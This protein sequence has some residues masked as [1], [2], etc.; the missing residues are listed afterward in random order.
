M[1][2][3]IG[4]LSLLAVPF[5]IATSVGCA[6]PPG[7]FSESNARAH[8]GMLAGTI[9]SRPVGTPANA[10]AR[11]YITE[12]LRLFGFEVRVQEADAR[13]A[14]LG[15]TARVSNIIAV[16]PGK[17]AEAMA[18][19]SHY[20]SVPEGP[21]AADNAFGVGVS[22]EAARVLAA[23]SDRNWTLMILITDGEEAGLMGAA[24]LVTDREIT[25]RLQ[26]YVNLEAIG[27][28]G[29]PTL[30]E[31]GPGNAWIVGPWARRAPHPSGGSFGLEIY[32]RLPND[33]DFSILKHQGIPG[34]N[35]AVVED[36]YAY[37]TARDTPERLSPATVRTAGEQVVAIMTALDGVD[38]TQRSA[39]TPTFFDIARRTAFFYSPIAN[40]ISAAAALLFGVVAWVRVTA[41]VIRLE[42]VLRWVLTTVWT[43][44]GSAAVIASMVGATWALRA[45]REVYHPWY[46]RPGRLFLL[47]IAVGLTV[48]WSS[49]RLGQWLPARAHGVRHPLVVWSIALPGWVALGAVTI[50]LVPGAAYLWLLPLLSAG[51]L[52]SIVPLRTTLAVR[53]VSAVVLLVSAALWLNPAKSM[54]FFM[55]PM[56][57]RLPVVTPSFVFAAVMAVAGLMLVPPLA[58]TVAKSRPFVR[59]SLETALCLI[60]VAAT[61]G[62][63]YV[64]PGYTDEQPLRR[65]ARAIQEGDG[66]ALWDVGSIEPGLDLGEG[67]PTG[68]MPSNTAPKAAVPLQRLPQP[69]VF[70]SSGPT[71]GPAPITIATATVEP[72]AAGA[73]LAVT[74]LPASPGLS[75]AFVL[76]PGLEP[77]RSN[78]PGVTRRDHWTATYRAPTPE[79]LVFRASFGRVD[80]NRLREL[81]VVATAEGSAD[82]AIWEVPPW[83]PS[84]RT[85]WTVDACWIVAPFALPI[86]PVPPLR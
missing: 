24:A 12:Q 14:S 66:P 6:R 49:A 71:L 18:I 21:G 53:A 86:A 42:G 81:R 26:A 85:A 70:R 73:E 44:A 4:R 62:F 57:G 65:S 11:T 74:V 68:W 7:L 28:S 54:L 64:A 36:S 63:A 51:L 75:I 32:R 41:V 31:T 45:A 23:R 37:H 77:A 8:I 40:S 78:L 46:A 43:L 9:G 17:R 55:V 10:T 76:P 1:G 19:V 67:A 20:D 48:G 38:I 50:W 82:G 27:S 2:L 80:T 58:A 72:L 83:L 79:G 13:R 60:A 29:P 3:S 35:F 59:P 56:F 15:L 39:I 47:L 61:A 30:F 52:L 34:L 33:T 22:L 25:S 84:S 69:F 5:A 16:R